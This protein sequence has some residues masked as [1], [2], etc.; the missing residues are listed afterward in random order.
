MIMLI[1]ERTYSTA[2][3]RLREYLDHHLAVALPIMRRHL[4]EPLAYYTSESGDAGEF[5]HLW[6]YIDSAEREAKRERL[7]AD[8]AWLAY[9]AATGATGWVTLQRN[10]LLRPVEIPLSTQRERAPC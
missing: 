9:R 6:P 3:G 10:R 2:P 4:G 8:P 7:Y 1:D 5:V